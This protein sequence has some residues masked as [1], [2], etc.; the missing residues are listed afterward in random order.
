MGAQAGELIVPWTLAVKKAAWMSPTSGTSSSPY[1]TFSE[2]WKRAAVSF[3]AGE[4]R[5]PAVG[6][7]LRFLRIF[8]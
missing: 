1:P 8:G 7:L 5:R 6:R 4:T 2:I 3:Y